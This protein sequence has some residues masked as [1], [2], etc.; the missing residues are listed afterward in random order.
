M[1]A[2]TTLNNLTLKQSDFL[3]QQNLFSSNSVLKVGQC[4]N[5]T[6]TFLHDMLQ[7]CTPI[8]FLFVCLFSK[9][10]SLKLHTNLEQH[11]L[12]AMYCCPDCVFGE[13]TMRKRFQLTYLKKPNHKMFI[14]SISGKCSR[15]LIFPNNIFLQQLVCGLKVLHFL[16]LSSA[17]PLSYNFCVVQ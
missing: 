10:V 14:L 13:H 1:S 16:C 5:Q 9:P 11:T 6:V 3:P 17:H 2:F 7:Y 15:F 4:S 12:K 8:F